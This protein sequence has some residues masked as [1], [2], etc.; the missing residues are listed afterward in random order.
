[1][2]FSVICHNGIGGNKQ[3]V[4]LETGSVYD[5]AGMVLET[6]MLDMVRFSVHVKKRE[7]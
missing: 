3:L 4:S 2:L 1:M 5:V 7:T 6:G